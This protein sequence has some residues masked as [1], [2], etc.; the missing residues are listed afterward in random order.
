MTPPSPTG[1]RGKAY[2]FEPQPGAA[3][4]TYEPQDKLA[5][6]LD[7]FLGISA[8]AIERA[9]ESFSPRRQARLWIQHR[10]TAAAHRAFPSLRADSFA[11]IYG[12][13]TGDTQLTGRVREAQMSTDWANLLGETLNR[14][15][16]TSYA[17][18]DYGERQLYLPATARDLRAQRIVN[19]AGIPDIPTIDAENN[20]Y[21][22]LGRL[23]ETALSYPMLQKG[24]IVTISRR[25]VINNDVDVVTRLVDGLGRAARRT[26]AREVWTLWSSNAVYGGDGLPWFDASRG[27]VQTSAISEAEV[28]AAVAKLLA[29]TEAG[30]GEKLGMR[31][32]PGDVWLAVPNV[33]WDAAYKLNN[34]T[35]SALLGFFGDHGEYIVVNPLLTDA[36]DWGVFRPSSAVESVRVSFYAGREEPELFLAD[37]KNAGEMFRADKLQYKLRFEFAAAVADPR[38]AVKAVVAG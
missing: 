6:A 29:Q 23:S 19:I 38:G 8:D 12:A 10:R 33:L 21:T 27:N 15:L 30:S 28:I 2:F 32:R 36:T 20:D 37:V 25:V 16:L 5:V 13:V 1:E 11:E 34:S 7:R 26:L 18:A 31:L 3:H 22:E 9:C 35:G 17:Q 4:V 14:L 24:V